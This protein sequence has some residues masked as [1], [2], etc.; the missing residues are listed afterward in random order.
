MITLHTNLKSGSTQ[1]TDY[2]FNSYCK[3]GDL[4]LCCSQSRIDKLDD[5]GGAESLVE[6]F[7]STLGWNGKKRNRYIYVGIET[8]G[9]IIITPLLDGTDGT[10]ITFTP[11]RTGRQYMRMTVSRDDSGY[12]W[13][14][15][16]QNVAGCW[17]AIDEVSVLPTY[18]SKGR[19]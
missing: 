16:I 14:Y 2:N 9:T 10:A 4:A 11:T 17:F 12:Y 1:L 3:F 13:A 15:R 8:E 6:T 5:A 19:K 18:L 7:V